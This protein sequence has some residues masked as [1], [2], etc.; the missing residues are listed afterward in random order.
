MSHIDDG[1][2]NALLDGELDAAE[3]DAVRSHVAG[4]AECAKRLEDAK[5][6]LAEAADLLGALDGPA[7]AAP[8]RVSRTAKEVAVDVDDATQQSPAIRLAQP[9][10]L[11][12]RP[13]K[14]RPE[15]RFDY[16]PLALA[17]MV[18]LALGVGYLANEVRHAGARAGGEAAVPPSPA[19]RPASA[20]AES[21]PANAAADARARDALGLATRTGA[22]GTA[23]GPPAAKAPPGGG[24]PPVPGR[25]ATGL[26]HKRLQTPAPRP[27]GARRPEQ[28]P[29]QLAEAGR[30]AGKASA[31]PAGPGVAGVLAAPPAS[32]AGVPAN[33]PT[34]RP[35]AVAVA[36]VDTGHAPAAR[37]TLA[38]RAPRLFRGAGGGGGGGAG[39]AFRSA[40]LEEA[41][42]SL[43]GTIRLVDG[44]QIERVQ[45]G[46]GRLVA[47][48]DSA[49]DVVRVTYTDAGQTLLLDQQRIDAASA[50]AG[51][52]AARAADAAQAAGDTVVTVAPD[53]S[54]Q[55][56]WQDPDGFWLSL[57]GRVPVDSLRHLIERVR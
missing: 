48:A 41:V 57:S 36:P 19:A 9:E 22:T 53:G 35:R 26:G 2:L 18:V 16:T 46:P 44:M 7:Q 27:G 54:R 42:S 15:R 11:M 32:E 23:E 40:T 51:A 38:A 29:A 52:G 49:A 17:A 55:A 45:I 39:G 34:R 37:E 31:V 5:R 12:R 20:P 1:M 47:G 50:A 33:A 24:E 30:A 4:C 28:P 3:A 14:P 25:A 43:G 8:R 10:P 6:F 13:P 21:L 56:R